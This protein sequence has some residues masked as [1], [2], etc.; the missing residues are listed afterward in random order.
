MVG[1]AVGS[2]VGELVGPVVGWNVCKTAGARVG[3]FD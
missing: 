3:D 2:F 1:E